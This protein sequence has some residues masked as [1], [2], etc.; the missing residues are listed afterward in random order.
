MLD[1]GPYDLITI[2]LAIAGVL[3]PIIVIVISY[4]IKLEHRLTVIEVLLN[5]RLPGSLYNDE[6]NRSSQ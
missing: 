4:A 3:A 5:D 2:S 1:V 6:K